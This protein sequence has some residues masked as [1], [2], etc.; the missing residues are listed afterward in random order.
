MNIPTH[1]E[2]TEYRH[3]T[4]AKIEKV[5]YPILTAR[6]YKTTL[7]TTEWSTGLFFIGDTEIMTAWGIK[8]SPHCSNHAVKVDGKWSKVQIGCPIAK[9][10]KKSYEIIG[11]EFQVDGKPVQFFS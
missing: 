9:P 4:P 5:E 7:D 11:I 1:S 6:F 3:D 2:W 8:A 10:I